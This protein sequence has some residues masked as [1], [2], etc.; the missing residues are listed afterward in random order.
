MEK[1]ALTGFKPQPYST[2][3]LWYWVSHENDKAQGA[4]ERGVKARDPLAV[5]ERVEY[6]CLLCFLACRSALLTH[7]CLQTD[8]ERR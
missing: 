4:L 8:S 1:Y 5:M 6:V 7:L 3:Y 2:L